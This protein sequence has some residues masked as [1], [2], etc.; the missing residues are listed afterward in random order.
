MR[1]AGS[2]DLTS[3]LE[4]CRAYLAVAPA[5]FAFSHETAAVLYAIPLPARAEG[6]PLHVS[7]PAEAAQVRRAGVI[8]HRGLE[9]SRL[10][11]G[12]PVVPPETVWLQLATTLSVDD[13]IVAGDHLLQGR[14]ALSTLERLGAEVESARGRRGVARAGAALLEL[15]IGVRSPRETRLRLLLVRAGLPEP[16]VGFQVHHEGAFVGTPDLAYPDL[17]IAIEYEGQHHRTDRNT[18]EDDIIRRELFR[19]AGWL[20]LLVT[21]RTFSRPPVLLGDLRALIAERA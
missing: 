19:R 20:V 8:G 1:L 18:Y 12:L 11:A 17:R 9:A 13:L 15:R 5:R 4:L 14:P 21:D 2:G 6:G 3:V 16:V 10:R 7:V